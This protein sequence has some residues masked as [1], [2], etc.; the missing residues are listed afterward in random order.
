MTPPAEH[1]AFDHL[2]HYVPDVPEAVAA[3]RATGLPA[4]TNEAMP[5]FHNGGW[6]LDTRYV[7]ILTVTDPQAVRTSLFA[8]GVELLRPAIEALPGPAGAITFAVNVDDARAT[9]A[10]LRAAGHEVAEFEVELAE[11]GVSFVEV[12]VLDGPPWHPFFITY[13]PPRDALLAAVDPDAFERG[14]HDLT[15]LVVSARDPR[16]A[17]RDLGELIGIEPTGSSLQLPGAAVHFEKG[18]REGLTAVTVSGDGP[19]PAVDV[20]GLGVRFGP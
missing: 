9:A 5:G 12:F 16:A 6:R 18:D 17:A 19:A 4:H 14:P 13:D 2:L 20:E 3:Y 8:R 7:E 10:R 15:G 11:H 1:P